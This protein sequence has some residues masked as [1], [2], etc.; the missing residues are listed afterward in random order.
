MEKN[1]MRWFGLAVLALGALTATLFVRTP[2]PRRTRKRVAKRPKV[3]PER[4]RSA[5]AL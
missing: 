4:W 2:P 5:G 1:G 3:K